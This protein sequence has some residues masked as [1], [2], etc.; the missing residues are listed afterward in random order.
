MTGNGFYS[1]LYFTM[2]SLEIMLKIILTANFKRC[3]ISS[4]L[5]EASEVGVFS[6]HRFHLQCN[7]SILSMPLYMFLVAVLTMLPSLTR[8][9]KRCPLCFAVVFFDPLAMNFSRCSPQ[10]FRW[11][12]LAGE[13]FQ[14]LA[15]CACFSVSFAWEIAR[16]SLIENIV[17][18]TIEKHTAA[19][20]ILLET[21]NAS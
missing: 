15:C 7:R 5:F 13:D 1:K 10:E 8:C 11:K 16:G 20:S 9:A 21:K 6:L 2:K 14:P 3:L 18:R 19:K 4:S 12:I 17:S